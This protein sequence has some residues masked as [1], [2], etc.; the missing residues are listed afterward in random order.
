MAQTKSEES[1]SGWTDNLPWLWFV[2]LLIG[3]IVQACLMI[4]YWKDLEKFAWFGDSFGT[5]NAYASSLALAGA[6]WAVLMQRRELKLQ[7][8]E[9]ALTRE[10]MELTRLEAKRS[11]DA[12]EITC[13]TMA[14]QLEQMKSSGT[15]E[16]QRYADHLLMTLMSE[17]VTRVQATSRSLFEFLGFDEYRSRHE[18]DTCE[19]QTDKTLFSMVSNLCGVHDGLLYNKI[20]NYNLSNANISFGRHSIEHTRS[21]P[22]ISSAD[23]LNS[24][25]Y[26]FAF[27]E[28]VATFYD[29]GICKPPVI[30]RTIFREQSGLLFAIYSCFIVLPETPGQT[31]RLPFDLEKLLRFRAVFEPVEEFEP[32]N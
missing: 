16:A 4:G 21:I 20:A 6:V 30:W 22:E 27:L 2:A 24:I 32:K 19:N 15:Y 10:E 17:S 1:Q 7:R 31:N 13:K 9:L 18:I 23:V 29:L 25:S 5:L 8:E 3:T 26:W 14:E 12:H 28:S 11:A